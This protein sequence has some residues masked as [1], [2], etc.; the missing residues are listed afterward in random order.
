M[1]THVLKHLR[2]WWSRPGRP[3]RAR[4]N[5]TAPQAAT[6]ESLNQ[7]AGPDLDAPERLFP[8]PTAFALCTHRGL[9]SDFEMQ[10]NRRQEG[11]RGDPEA[12][13]KPAAGHP[14]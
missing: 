6:T 1:T 2:L 10:T 13:K 4:A 12:A 14:S 9:R 8:T 5:R 3:A 11:S 7:E